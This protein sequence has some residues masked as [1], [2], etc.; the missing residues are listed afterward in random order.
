M[1]LC[2]KD[3]LC[4]ERRRTIAALIVGLVLF[5]N[6]TVLGMIIAQYHVGADLKSHRMDNIHYIDRDDLELV[7]AWES[8][9]L[10]CS[11]LP[12][13]VFLCALVAMSLSTILAKR[14]TSY[15]ILAGWALLVVLE[16][17]G[18]W[19]WVAFWVWGEG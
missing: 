9:G 11:Q 1:S 15:L 17:V 10:F 2:T 12:P 16:I 8:A 6:G 7:S 18:W 5:A 19:V 13:A 4:P 3:G 14:R